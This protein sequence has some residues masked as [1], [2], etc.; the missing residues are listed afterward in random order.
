[1]F[2]LSVISTL[3]SEIVTHAGAIIAGLALGA[4]IC[5]VVVFVAVKLLGVEL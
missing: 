5:A 2:K 3:V 1:M 4:T